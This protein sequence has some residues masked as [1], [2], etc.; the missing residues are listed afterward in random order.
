MANAAPGK[1]TITSTTGPGITNTA[2]V[3]TDVNDLEFDFLHNVVK[4]TRSG[5]GGILYYDLSA[6]ATGT[7]SFTAGLPTFVL[8]T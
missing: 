7:I 2:Q 5:A 6:L 3:F 4:V 1:L 8:S